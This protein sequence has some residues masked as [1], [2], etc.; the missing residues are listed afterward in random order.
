MYLISPQGV[1]S[2]STIESF[3]VACSCDKLAK[4]EIACIMVGSRR[5]WV[6]E[7]RKGRD[8]TIIFI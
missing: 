1:G 3:G 2:L 6:R 8:I 5:V 7:T 4:E